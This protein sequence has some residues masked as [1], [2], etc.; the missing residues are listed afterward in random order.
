VLCCRY[1]LC[2]CRFH[3]RGN[4]FGSLWYGLGGH[5][6]ER[7]CHRL[8]LGSHGIHR[9]ANHR[10]N[11]RRNGR[12]RVDALLALVL[13]D[14]QGRVLTGGADLRYVV[15]E[16]RRRWPAL[17]RTL[18]AW[19][20]ITAATKTTPATTTTAAAA[21]ALTLVVT[22]RAIRALGGLCGASLRVPT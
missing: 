4:H 10:L 22:V 11:G 19:R 9:Y 16:F 6:L 12:D 5:R 3:Y 17:G 21:F 13:F 20:A 2:N 7:R 18:R 1:C 14:V 8:R 15:T